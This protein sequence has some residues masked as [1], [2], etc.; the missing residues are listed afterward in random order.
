M[1]T[2]LCVSPASVPTCTVLPRGCLLQ[3]K[4]RNEKCFSLVRGSSLR[5]PVE[6]A[7]TKKRAAKYLTAAFSWQTRKQPQD[8]V[9]FQSRFPLFS[10]SFSWVSHLL[11]LFRSCTGPRRKHAV[12]SKRIRD[13]LLTSTN[14]LCGESH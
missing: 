10:L 9:L 6:V 7:V 5:R 4:G 1:Q 14:H 2:F 3:F 8:S 13:E 11:L 12:Q